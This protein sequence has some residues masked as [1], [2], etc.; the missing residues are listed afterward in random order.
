[1]INFI[2]IYFLHPVIL[3][4][5]LNLFTNLKLNDVAKFKILIA[6]TIW[7]LTAN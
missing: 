4:F 7:H 2:Y 1:M 5:P 3:N 6:E